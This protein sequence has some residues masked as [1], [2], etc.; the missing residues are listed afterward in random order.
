MQS[1]TALDRVVIE[2]WA[3]L[4]EHERF[5]LLIPFIVEWRQPF[6]DK[7]HPAIIV[8]VKLGFVEPAGNPKIIL[9]GSRT[10]EL[11][12][13]CGKMRTLPTLYR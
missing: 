11:S 12:Q 1:K 3:R 5:K 4:S 9:T 6:S 10:V 13:R 7:V 8:F 2:V